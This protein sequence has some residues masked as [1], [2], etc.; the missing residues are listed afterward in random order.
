M[1]RELVDKIKEKDYRYRKFQ[2]AVQQERDAKKKQVD[3]EKQAKLEVERERLRK[4]REDLA[5]Q[6]QKEEDEAI[7]RGDFDEV[8]VEEFRCEI[9]KKTYRKEG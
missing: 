7:A 2:L 4:Y 1:V 9:C 5:I 6:Y 8:F 3:E